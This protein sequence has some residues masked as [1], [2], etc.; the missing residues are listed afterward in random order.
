[1]KPAHKT[2]KPAAPETKPTTPTPPPLPP[3]L[4]PDRV[5]LP[6]GPH[7]CGFV[8]LVGRPN[9]GKST[10]LNALVGQKIAATTAKPQ[11][12]R[13]RLRGVL[14]VKGAQFIFV[15]TP[16]L[17]DGAWEDKQER[18]G[19]YGQ[20]GHFMAR[21]TMAALASVDAVVWLVDAEDKAGPLEPARGAIAGLVR[22]SGKPWVLAINKVDRVAKPT[23]L[24]MM[25]TWHRE[26]APAAIVPVCALRAN[27]L[28][29]LVKEV[30]AL[31]PEGERM[32]PDT[33]LTDA[34]EREVVGELIREK[35]M[36]LTKQ[37]VP[38]AAAVEIE[39][40][41][42][43]RREA[44]GRRKTLVEID[45]AIH[46]ERDGQKAILVGKGGEMIKNIGTLARQEV[47]RFLGCQVMLKLFV[48]VT[49]GWTSNPRDLGD[50]GYR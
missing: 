30:A 43:T 31:L 46:V 27:G 20:L 4:Q 34:S 45:A 39:R 26:L 21:E 14:T 23:L 37:E 50:L 40:F 35:V 8:A 9:V 24:P 1:V 18:G 33:D 7:R 13:R 16:G 2:A 47:E 12:T 22:G 28:D 48:K 38:Y 17:F 15:D 36:A 11:T 3:I 10:M 5:T 41:D 42:E 29:R 19:R 6:E 25:E 49:E 44:E 32:F